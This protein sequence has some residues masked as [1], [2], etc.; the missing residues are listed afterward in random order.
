MTPGFI[1][2]L[3]AHV[4]DALIVCALAILCVYLLKQLPF[5][6]SISAKHADRFFVLLWFLYSISFILACSATPG[7]LLLGMQIVDACS[8]EPPAW[9]RIVVRETVG[10]IMSALFFSLG[11]LWIAFDASKRGWHDYISGTQVVM[12]PSRPRKSGG[13]L[14]RGS[15][16]I[17][18]PRRSSAAVDDL[19]FK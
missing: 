10:K 15:E 4:I 17:T 13:H 8:E 9:W 3:I 14:P 11:F 2:R 5:A 16:G 18:V 19:I 12:L 1:L 6:D 7:K